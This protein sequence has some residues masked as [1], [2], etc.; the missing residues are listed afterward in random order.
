MAEK[1]EFSSGKRVRLFCDPAIART[2]EI[3][4]VEH[5]R[6]VTA[7]HANKMH[8]SWYDVEALALLDMVAGTPSS[9]YSADREA[10]KE[11]PACFLSLRL[12]IQDMSRQSRSRLSLRPRS[13]QSCKPGCD[14][15]LLLVGCELL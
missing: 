7:Q 1:D 9:Q 10:E 3:D 14:S 12:K 2:F 11:V 4:I 15:N 6:E 13:L 5:E 8:G